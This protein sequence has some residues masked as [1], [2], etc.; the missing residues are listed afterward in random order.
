MG[1]KI[2]ASMNRHWKRDAA[3]A[4]VSDAAV[5]VNE[6]VAMQEPAYEPEFDQQPNDNDLSNHDVDVAMYE[7]DQLSDEY[8]TQF[9]DDVYMNESN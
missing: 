5:D 2:P 1:L 9:D 8:D 7:F 4:A 6:D 3:A